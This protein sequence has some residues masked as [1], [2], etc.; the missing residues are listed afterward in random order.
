VF[1]LMNN[2]RFGKIHSGVHATPTLSR[3]GLRPDPQL[4]IRVRRLR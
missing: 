3:S 4:A 1:P 2:V